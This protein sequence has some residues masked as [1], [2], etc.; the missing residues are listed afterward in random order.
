MWFY[1]HVNSL[2][3]IEP[4]I[5]QSLSGVATRFANS[6]HFPILFTQWPLANFRN[7]H[8]LLSNFGMVT[9]EKNHKCITTWPAHFAAGINVIHNTFTRKG[10]NKRKHP[11]EGHPCLIQWRPSPFMIPSPPHNH[12]VTVMWITFIPAAKQA[13]LGS[14][15]FLFFPRFLMWPCRVIEGVKLFVMFY[16][17]WLDK[18]NVDWCC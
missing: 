14:L 4:D 16:S 8:S 11:R 5:S 7:A 13:D 15:I 6:P 12:Y 18:L 9:I 17:I 10:R 1:H 3:T 2:R